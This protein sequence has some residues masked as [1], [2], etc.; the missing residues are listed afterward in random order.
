M[1]IYTYYVRS[2]MIEKNHMR[3]FKHNNLIKGN[4]FFSISLLTTFYFTITYPIILKK[5]KENNI[6]YSCTQCF[7]ES[8]DFDGDSPKQYLTR[9][10]DFVIT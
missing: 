3:I 6:P 8:F 4:N 5:T 7:E 2:N 10:G 9:S 1:N